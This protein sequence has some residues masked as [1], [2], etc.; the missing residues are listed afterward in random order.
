MSKYPSKNKDIS[1]SDNG[2]DKPKKPV[3][4]KTGFSDFNTTQDLVSNSKFLQKNM[5]TRSEKTSFYYF[6]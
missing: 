2:F 6:T 4:M 3:F 5:R 1:Y